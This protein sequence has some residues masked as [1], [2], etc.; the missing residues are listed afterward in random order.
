MFLEPRPT[1]YDLRFRLFGIPIGIHPFFWFVALLLGPLQGH[2]G[3]ELIL[4]LSAWVAALFVS[5][6]V[7]EL[8]HALTLKYV[9]GAVPRIVLY[10]AGGLTLYEPVYYRRKP[11]TWGEILVSFA[12]PATGF[13]LA[14]VIGVF[15]L[16]LQF[17]VRQLPEF[18][19]ALLFNEFVFYFFVSVVWIS[20]VWGIFNLLPIYPLDGGQICRELC[21]WFSPRRG[22]VVSLFISITIAVFGAA[23]AIF[24]WMHYPQSNV[25][26]MGIVFLVLAVQNISI[27]QAYHRGYR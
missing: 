9:F 12:G 14:F 23:L 19:A 26:F 18:L 21:L 27:L 5:I 17:Q 7:H 24:L 4:L 1:V 6:L 16:L 25:H 13:L 3:K 15:G 2:H 22:I 20:V 11:G 8:G 10:L